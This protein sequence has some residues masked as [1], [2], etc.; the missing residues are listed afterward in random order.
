MLGENLSLRL[1]VS[2]PRSGS[3]DGFSCRLAISN[4]TIVRSESIL[5]WRGCNDEKNVDRPRN[6]GPCSGDG[7][8][9]CTPAM[10]WFERCKAWGLAGAAATGRQRGSLRGFRGIAAH[11][12]HRRAVRLGSETAGGCR[13][14]SI[15]RGDRVRLRA[16]SSSFCD[17]SGEAGTRL[18][19]LR[20]RRW[21]IRPAKDF[22]IRRENW[23]RRRRR[24]T[25]YLYRAVERNREEDLIRVFG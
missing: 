18:I 7:R 1:R 2:G 13:L 23:H 8:L 24:R 12:V 17:C 3:Q 19:S 15:S 16:G 11:R 6:Y 14:R 25:R 4:G 9:L 20:R 5:R 22:R 21:K 10:G